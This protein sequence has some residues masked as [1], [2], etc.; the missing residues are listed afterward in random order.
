MGKFDW[1]DIYG[2]ESVDYIADYLVT[3]IV[4]AIDFFSIS[5]RVKKKEESLH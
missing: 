1:F 3:N 2:L 4:D 5:F